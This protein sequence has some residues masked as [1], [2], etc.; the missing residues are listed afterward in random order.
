[1]EIVHRSSG[2]QE[3]TEALGPYRIEALLTEAEEGA[4]TVYRVRIEPHQK[5]T[6][7][8]HRIAEEYYFVLSGAGTAILNG[9][10]RPLAAG[11]FLRLPPGTR[12]G[13]VTGDAPLEMLDIHTPGCRPRRDTYFVEERPPGF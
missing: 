1:M 4:G 7:S 13:F 11:D 10:P 12:H 8:Y 9:E 3:R 6:I 2:D 5:T